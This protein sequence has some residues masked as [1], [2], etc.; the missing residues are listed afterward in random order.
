MGIARMLIDFSAE[1]EEDRWSAVNDGVMGGLSNS[2]LVD[3]SDSTAFFEG[4]LSVENN[5]GFASIRRELPRHPLTGANAV[6]LDVRG[7]GRRYQLR[8]RTDDRFDGVAYRAFFDTIDGVWQRI[9]IP[10]NEFRA[11][12]RGSSVPGAP[13]LEPERIQQLGFL[14][15]DKRPGAFRL[16][17]RRIE[18][19][20]DAAEH[21]RR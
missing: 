18:A 13:V 9:E 12:F 16:E 21:Q 10:F 14:I 8:V 11:T 15:A 6:I 4:V 20:M 2:R 5:G 7:D 3:A 1:G 19:L 17:I